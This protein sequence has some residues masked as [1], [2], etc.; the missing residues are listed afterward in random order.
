MITVNNFP[1]PERPTNLRSL[2]LAVWFFI[3]AEA[4][5]NSADEFSSLP[6]VKMTFVPSGI[7]LREITLKGTGRVLLHLQ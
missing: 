3:M 4:F 6:A 2:N 1:L 5:L 7:S